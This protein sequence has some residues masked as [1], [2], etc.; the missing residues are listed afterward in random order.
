M[1]RDGA[2]ELHLMLDIRNKKTVVSFQ[3]PRCG[4]DNDARIEKSRI[5]LDCERCNF[6]DSAALTELARAT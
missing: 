4:A 1:S 2:V 3:C 6:R 5:W